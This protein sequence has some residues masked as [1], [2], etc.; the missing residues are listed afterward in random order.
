MEPTRADFEWKLWGFWTLANILGWGISVSSAI[1]VTG[2]V[3]GRNGELWIIPSALLIGLAQWLV[4]ARRFSTSGWLIPAYGLGWYIGLWLGWNLGFIT[5]E[6]LSL[7]AVGGILVGAMQWLGMRRRLYRSWIWIP[8]LTASSLLG[9]WLGVLAG[10]S[11]YDNGSVGE[12][13]A[14]AIGGA[15]AGAVIGV[16]S[17]SVLIILMRHDASRKA[18][19]P[20]GVVP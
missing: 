3:A 6:P 13:L 7:G 19:T 1:Y 9:C 18:G 11:A 16:L 20:A 8:T 2:L 5:P 15:V 10:V 17:G 14:Y 12:A 4:F